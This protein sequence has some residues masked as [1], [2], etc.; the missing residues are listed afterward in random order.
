VTAA[1][2]IVAIVL[3]LPAMAADEQRC[4]WLNAATAGGLLGGVVQVT[5]T[6]TS[7][8]FGRQT[9][10]EAATLWI[11]VNPISAPHPH[12]GPGAEPLA[13]IGNEAAAC[14][15]QGKPGW[16]AEQ[17]VGRVRDHAFLVRIGTN[18]NSAR[19]QALREKVRNLAEQVA[20][21]LF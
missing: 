8:E 18:N 11:E 14:A 2:G 21:I 9:G 13:A 17:V 20:G 15:Y 4:P 6:G 3:A 7:C 10:A 12:C 1:A 19:A 16:M 5:V